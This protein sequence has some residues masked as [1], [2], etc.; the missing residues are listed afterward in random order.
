LAELSTLPGVDTKGEPFVQV[1]KDRQAIA[2]MSPAAAI[3]YG[4]G[5]ISAAMEA[6]TDAG[7]YKMTMTAGRSPKDAL[8]LIQSLRAARDAYLLNKEGSRSLVLAGTPTP[9]SHN[10]A[11]GPLRSQLDAPNAQETEVVAAETTAEV[12]R[13]ISDMRLNSRGRLMED[14]SADI[15][16]VRVDHYAA[17]SAYAIVINDE[18]M[19]VNPDKGIIKEGRY[20]VAIT[21][22]GAL[23]T[24]KAQHKRGAEVV[25]YGI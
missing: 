22:R 17:L 20:Y 13:S 2:S 9:T 7:A 10:D 18:C 14:I 21:Q 4:L 25:V 23:H 12:P 15:Q 6:V 24:D 1:Y 8:A 11:P 5:V 19:L 16:R 3:E